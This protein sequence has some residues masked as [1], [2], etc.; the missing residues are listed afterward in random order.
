[1]YLYS[2]IELIKIDVNIT[3]GTWAQIYILSLVLEYLSK[4]S[5]HGIA[6]VLI[7]VYYVVM[8]YTI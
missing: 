1:M 4:F 6:F 7:L 8:M 3:M 5:T 2:F